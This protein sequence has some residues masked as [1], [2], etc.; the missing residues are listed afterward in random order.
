[1]FRR[2]VKEHFWYFV[3]LLG[4]IG[5]TTLCLYAFFGSRAIYSTDSQNAA[6]ASTL[7]ASLYDLPKISTIVPAKTSGE[8]DYVA[9]S[10][11]LL[12]DRIAK[13]LSPRPALWVYGLLPAYFAK[14]AQRNHFTELASESEDSLRR[15]VKDLEALKKIIE[16]MPL[17]DLGGA[18]ADDRGLGERLARTKKGIDQA[19]EYI[20][21]S[22]LPHSKEITESLL[23]LNNQTLTLTDETK[24]AWAEDLMVVQKRILRDIEDRDIQQS[25]MQ[26]RL[27][28]VADSY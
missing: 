27:Q 21:W 15:T 14:N 24:G 10:R 7:S 17:V 11:S 20:R 23:A 22:G 13:E 8:T 1:M 6:R 28:A 5:I 9:T 2:F 12:A 19:A 26:A 4:T 18:F 3:I 16:Y 25:D